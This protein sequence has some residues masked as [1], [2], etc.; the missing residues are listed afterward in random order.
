LVTMIN[1]LKQ[2]GGV[3]FPSGEEQERALKAQIDA[4]AFEQIGVAGSFLFKAGKHRRIAV[5]VIDFR[6]KWHE[7]RPDYLI[8]LRCPNGG[9][10]KV[11][12]EVKGL[13]TNPDR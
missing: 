8:R 2:Q 6:G 1:L 3:L 9:E 10:L 12:L 4:E 11:I 7:Y 13:E 5:E